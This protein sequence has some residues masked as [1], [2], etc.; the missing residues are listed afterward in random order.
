MGIDL[1][2]PYTL[3]HL[4]ALSKHMAVTAEQRTMLRDY[5]NLTKRVTRRPSH[6]DFA[7][8]CD[9]REATEII[10]ECSEVIKQ[11]VKIE[12]Q[13]LKSLTKEQKMD[14]PELSSYIQEQGDD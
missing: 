12:K 6:R 8:G 5:A 11:L 13:F 4:A 2:N 7:Y 1:T 3:Q 10:Y 9:I 14:V